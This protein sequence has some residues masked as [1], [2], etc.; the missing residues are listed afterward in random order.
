MSQQTP[1]DSI[2]L[3]RDQIQTPNDADKSVRAVLQQMVDAWNAGDGTAFAAP[4]TDEVDFIVW[5]GTHLEGRQELAVFT[6]QIFDAV[7][8]G[9][10]LEGE[11]K[12]VRF[13]SPTLAVMHSVVRTTLAGQTK[14]L[15]SRDSMELIVVTKRDGQWRGQSL[16][17]ARRLTMERQL[18]LDDID[19]LPA[20]AQRQVSDLVAS[21]KR[22]RH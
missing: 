15:P 12:F 19:S 5:E 3:N 20:D 11:V 18:V 16:M 22:R 6:Q 7:V 4:F 17:D 9:S 8:K 10:R 1:I 2:G 21:L 14:A 13:L